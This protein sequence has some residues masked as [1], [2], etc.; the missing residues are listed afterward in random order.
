VAYTCYRLKA[1]FA[2]GLG[3]PDLAF[4]VLEPIFFATSRDTLQKYYHR[5]HQVLMRSKRK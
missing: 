5:G 4:V 3:W 2:G 1:G